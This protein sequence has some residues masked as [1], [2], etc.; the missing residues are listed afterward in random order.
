MSRLAAVTGATGFVG[1][2]LV[3]ALLDAGWRVRV[4]ARDPARLDA[5]WRDRVEV[6]QGDAASASAM[7]GFLAG[8]D[9]AY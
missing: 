6:V 7:E 8:V 9:A 5:A 2:A 3:P 1:S 4:L